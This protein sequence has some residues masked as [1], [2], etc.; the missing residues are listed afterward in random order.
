MGGAVASV[1]AN[2]SLAKAS[3]QVQTL[4]LRSQMTVNR[5]LDVPASSDDVPVQAVPG[6][7]TELPSHGQRATEAVETSVAQVKM[8]ASFGMKEMLMKARRESYVVSGADD[9]RVEASTLRDTEAADDDDEKMLDALDAVEATRRAAQ[10]IQLNEVLT[11]VTMLECAANRYRALSGSSWRPSRVKF[12]QQILRPLF[13]DM[14][15]THAYEHVGLDPI[16]EIAKT[17]IVDFL[18][19]YMAVCAEKLDTNRLRMEAE[20]SR[21]KMLADYCV[22]HGCSFVKGYEELCAH[23]WD[24]S[25]S[26]LGLK[27]FVRDEEYPVGTDATLEALCASIRAIDLTQTRRAIPR[28]TDTQIAQ[29]LLLAISADIPDSRIIRLL[30]KDVNSGMQ[31]KALLLAASR[32]RVDVL[33]LLSR[34]LSEIPHAVLH[35]ALIVGAKRG[36]LRTVR[37]MMGFADHAT[38]EKAIA[39]AAAMD[40]VHI[41]R[42]LLP[43][44]EPETWKILWAMGG[45][46]TKRFHHVLATQERFRWARYGTEEPVPDQTPRT[47]DATS[48]VCHDFLHV[49][50]LLSTLQVLHGITFDQRSMCDLQAGAG[51]AVLAACLSQSFRRAVGFEEDRELSQRARLA[52]ERFEADMENLF[53]P[54][55]EEVEVAQD[56]DTAA[57][58][59]SIPEIHFKKGGRPQQQAIL[60]ELQ[61]A[62]LILT[63][64]MAVR[65]L[66]VRALRDGA[67]LAVYAPSSDTRLLQ[68]K[69]ALCKL[70]RIKNPV[71]GSLILW[72]VYLRRNDEIGE[73]FT[74]ETHRVI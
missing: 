60:H 17:R 8:P 2:A 23:G 32:D 12:T 70:H 18:D 51:H 31:R 27:A 26:S 28:C 25:R 49:D 20:P 38:L 47:L 33:V 30:L 62:H 4:A 55:F 57:T 67:V 37:A 64:P 1:P 46:R 6:C 42:R 44:M 5:L 13:L 24:V 9:N 19:A 22:L 72:D 39:I 52:V 53:V 11:Q 14:M 48:R 41:V 63:T 56:E 65:A 50:L 40:H 54:S 58:T 3:L 16:E 66:D 43:L 34:L 61:Q 7:G 10:R 69:R 74:E 36:A 29:G 71:D 59:T 68:R 35:E 15:R 73:P 21:A 45:E